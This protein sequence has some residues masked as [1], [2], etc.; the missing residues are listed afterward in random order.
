MHQPCVLA[1]L[2]KPDPYAL[3]TWPANVVVLPPVTR[4]RPLERRAAAQ[5]AHRG[6]ERGARRPVVC[7]YCVP[8]S[9]DEQHGDRPDAM[10]DPALR[11]AARTPEFWRDQIARRVPDDPDVS[12]RELLGTFQTVY[13]RRIAREIEERGL[14]TAAEVADALR[15]G[16]L[17]RLGPE[18]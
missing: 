12:G 14:S 17:G 10:P 6:R 4:P 15:R 13:R 5:A 11:E 16:D 1:G 18:R 3:R 7:A 8:V 2:G 9:D